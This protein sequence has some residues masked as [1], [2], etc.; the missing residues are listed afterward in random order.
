MGDVEAD[1]EIDQVGP[2]ILADDDVFALV[3]I[4]VGNPA[5]VHLAECSAQ[6]REEVAPDALVLPQRMARDEHRATALRSRWPFA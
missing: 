1:L 3:E 4:D 2:A 5:D 6:G